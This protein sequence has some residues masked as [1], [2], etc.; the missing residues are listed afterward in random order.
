LFVVL[1]FCVG[2]DLPPAPLPP[3]VPLRG[4]AVPP[5]VFRAQAKR[6]LAPIEPTQ[7]TVAS[8]AEGSIHKIFSD[9]L[10]L[11]VGIT[12]KAKF[13]VP[14]DFS[15]LPGSGHV[16]G[17]TIRVYGVVKNS[18]LYAFWWDYWIPNLELSAKAVARLDAEGKRRVVG[19]ATNSSGK[20]VQDLKI[21][22]ILF[23]SKHG[24]GIKVVEV[25]DV[26]PGESKDFTAVFECADAESK[27]TANVV[28]RVASYRKPTK[29]GQAS[30]KSKGD[31]K[32]P[33]VGE[34]TRI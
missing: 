8:Y 6:I 24:P 18:R 22:L 3:E 19:K 5:E 32:T 1:F 34:A 29:E 4:K 33:K 25:G 15:K 26:E 23:G 16:V 20:L 21:E 14:V 12:G 13:L 17:D 9:S 31:K 11:S 7:T 10:Q 27:K 2:Q 28:V 30:P